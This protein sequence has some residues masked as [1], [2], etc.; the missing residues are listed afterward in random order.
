MITTTF[1]LFL[2]S[3]LFIFLLFLIHAKDKM[4]YKKIP[5]KGKRKIIKWLVGRSKKFKLWKLSP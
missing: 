1:F 5:K 4:L 2:Y 3:Y